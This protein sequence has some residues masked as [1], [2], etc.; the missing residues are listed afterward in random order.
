[1]VPE[2]SRVHS[3]RHE[4][5][6]PFP[7]TSCHD[8]D[9]Q[10]HSPLWLMTTRDTSSP[11]HELF[12][13]ILK[14]MLRGERKLIDAIGQFAEA[15]TIPRLKTAFQ[16]HQLETRKHAD[17][18]E[19]IFVLLG[20]EPQP[21][22]CTAISGLIEEAREYIAEFQRST[23]LD[24][25]L[26]SISQKIKHYEIAVYSTLVALA[27]RLGYLNAVHTFSQTLSEERS[28]DARLSDIAERHSNPAALL[29]S[30]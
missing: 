21:C 23:A 18:L 19:S 27:G 12:L 9:L 10:F 17:R 2:I 25:A 16:N 7:G 22:K 13:T 1:M 26:V 20:R 3:G 30:S 6:A 4:V 29:Q 24:S 15:A 5:A 14:E 28:M 8:D 11:L